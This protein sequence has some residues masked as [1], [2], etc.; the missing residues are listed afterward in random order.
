MSKPAKPDWEAFILANADYD[1]TRY[2]AVAKTPMHI[3]LKRIHVL[4]QIRHK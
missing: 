3:L 2:Q 4:K 1:V